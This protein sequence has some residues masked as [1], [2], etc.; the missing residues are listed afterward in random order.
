M[1]QAGPEKRTIKATCELRLLQSS[2]QAL[3]FYDGKIP[4]KQRA[5]RGLWTGHV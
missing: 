4:R 1:S 5:G 3:G 2:V